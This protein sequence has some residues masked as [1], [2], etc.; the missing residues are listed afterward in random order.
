MYMGSHERNKIV[1]NRRFDVIQTKRRK[2]ELTCSKEK[3]WSCHIL[4][5][6]G[7]NILKEERVE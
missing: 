2:T 6:N 4:R 7:T 5:D 1:E 3:E